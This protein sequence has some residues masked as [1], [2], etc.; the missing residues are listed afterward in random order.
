MVPSLVMVVDAIPLT[1]N[2]KIDRRALPIPTYQP[3]ITPI[4]APQTS[5]ET[6]LAEIW[7]PL[8]GVGSVSVHDN[9][10]EAG[11]HSLLATQFI[12]RI[13]DVLQIEIPLRCLFET[14]TIA[15]LAQSIQTI[16]T[17][18]GTALS[19]RIPGSEP[20]HWEEVEL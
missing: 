18:Q 20:H 10:F 7:S 6:T 14:P 9:F 4:V 8:L 13:R 1:P 5:I 12:S 15:G 19:N 17:A 11:G 3:T 2:G 16:Q